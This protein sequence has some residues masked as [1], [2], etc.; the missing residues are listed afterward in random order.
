MLLLTICDRGSST[1]SGSATSPSDGQGSSATSSATTKPNTPRKRYLFG[2]DI[3]DEQSYPLSA[4][5]RFKD[6]LSFVIVKATGG[7]DYVDRHFNAQY[8][9]SVKDSGFARGAYHFFYV[10]DKPETQARHFVNTVGVWYADDFP[11]IVDFEKKS[12]KNFQTADAKLYG[13]EDFSISTDSVQARL[14]RF[15]QRVEVLT[16]RLP[17]IYSSRDRANEYLDN[18]AFAAYPLW[19][20][21]PDSKAIK[22]RIP[23]TWKNWVLWQKG[24]ISVEGSHSDTDLDAFHG[25]EAALGRFMEH[26]IL[27]RDKVPRR[28]PNPT[29]P[30]QSPITPNRN[31]RKNLYGIDISDNQSYNLDN[32]RGFR[33][34][35][36]FVI[37]KATGGMTF[38]DHRFRQ[39][40]WQTIKQL[41]F[42]RGAYHFYYV[43][44]N[45]HTQANH[46]VS[47][48]GKWEVDDFPPIVD[49][50]GHSFFNFRENKL[51]QSIPIERVQQELLQFLESVKTKTGRLPIIYSNLSKAN[52]Y[53]ST[54]AFAEYPLWIADPNNGLSAP[55]LPVNW[56]DKGW[57]LWQK[58][59]VFVPNKGYK[60]TDF[61]EFNGNTFALKR[62]LRSTVLTQGN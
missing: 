62:F 31:T 35:L 32:L 45:P 8:W 29:R 60:H 28:D 53:L 9:Q 40:D 14:L 6:S 27:N 16:G 49:F 7:E 21:A 41:G 39:G 59:Y 19:I 12:F 33:D 57:V 54:A 34:S 17:I 3:S 37:V 24:K 48:V 5:D 26:T 4:L 47:T 42:T 2:V 50:E 44:D 23:G 52:K 25:D 46:F 51:D 15:L 18:P 1:Q 11:P 36:S 61:D 10:W 58:G 38:V 13:K 55:H 56:K 43:W 22:P 30:P 20:A